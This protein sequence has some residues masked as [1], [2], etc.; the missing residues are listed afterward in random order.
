VDG[1]WTRETLIVMAKVFDYVVPMSKVNEL[2]ETLE[3]YI[4]GDRSKLKWLID[5]RITKNEPLAT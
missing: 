1:E 3:A 4:G 2:A 5:F